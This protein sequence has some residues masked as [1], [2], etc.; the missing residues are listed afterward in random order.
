MSL[1][2]VLDR[3]GEQY[4]TGTPQRGRSFLSH[5]SPNTG[6]VT[7]SHQLQCP[8]PGLLSERFVLTFSPMPFDLVLTLVH[9]SDEEQR[10]FTS[11]TV[12]Q[13]HS[14]EECWTVARISNSFA[15]CHGQPF[16]SPFQLHPTLSS[17]IQ[18]SLCHLE[19]Y[20]TRSSLF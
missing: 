20:P 11:P 3:W 4:P 15:L 19:L 1:L 5:L 8:A 14:E 17:S 16:E 13:L 7:V 18:P 10:F 2:T 6:S 12:T 9:R